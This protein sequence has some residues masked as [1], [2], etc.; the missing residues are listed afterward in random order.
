MGHVVVSISGGEIVMSL[1]VSVAGGVECGGQC[2]RWW[3][4]GVCGHCSWCGGML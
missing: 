1:V 2:S 4:F 3:I